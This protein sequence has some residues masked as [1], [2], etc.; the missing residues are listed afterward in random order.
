MRR[1]IPSLTAAALAIGSIA[2]AL[3][4]Q[5]YGLQVSTSA[6]GDIVDTLIR[7]DSQS[8]GT[9]QTIGQISGLTAG[10]F[11]V[12][13]DIRPATDQLYGFSTL[14][15][16]YTI[17]TATAAVTAVGSPVPVLLS[18]A[19]FGT[20]FNPTVDRL[21]I[22]SDA[23]ENF[24]LDPTTGAY[25]ADTAVKYPGATS[26]TP[27]PLIVGSAYTNNSASAATTTLY[28][29]DSATNTLFIQNPP[30]A[31]TLTA[32]GPLGVTLDTESVGFDISGPSGIAYAAMT[33]NAVTGLYTIDLATGAASFVGPIGDGSFAV[34]G[35][36]AAVPEP[37]SLALLML[38]MMALALRIRRA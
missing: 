1:F 21:R 29:I 16:L 5:L 2:P 26:T 19:F 24:R 12:G 17:N 6:G 15:S 34:E 14:G 35:L 18:G 25:I 32:V 36:A 37:G 27:P 8:P 9:V 7:F 33:V 28:D 4:E 11:L 20:D 31:G 13:A 30:N 3:A 22:V 23:G 38:G 10:D